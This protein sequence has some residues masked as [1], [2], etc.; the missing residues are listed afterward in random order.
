MTTAI[1]T[2]MGYVLHQVW[3]S[4]L[5]KS[6]K[7]HERAIAEQM[8]LVDQVQDD[9]ERLNKRCDDLTRQLQQVKGEHRV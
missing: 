1:L 8:N 9:L 2:W 6:K 3:R 4:K 5:K 7:D